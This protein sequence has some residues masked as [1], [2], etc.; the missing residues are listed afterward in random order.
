MKY[1]ALISTVCRIDVKWI[2]S[3]VSCE[4]QSYVYGETYVS[5]YGDPAS[6]CTND[7][8]AAGSCDITHHTSATLELGNMASYGK[9]SWSQ[10]QQLL[11][12]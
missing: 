5:H 8:D 1:L 11:F 6:E 3:H 4:A 2:G 12:C 9:I 7:L 10:L